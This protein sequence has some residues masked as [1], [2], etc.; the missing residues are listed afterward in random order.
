MP[1]LILLFTKIGQ[2]QSCEELIDFVKSE[3]YGATYNSPTSTAIS[4]VSFHTV[5]IDYDTYYF[6]IVCFKSK[7]S[8]DCT[9]YIYRVASNTKLYY[10]MNYINSAGEAFWKYI[11][12]YH[13]NSECSP[14]LEN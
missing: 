8:Y 1:F 5:Y 7:Y 9:E 3:D 11:Q 6:A 13:K 14:S 4:K 2:S 12:P 10:S